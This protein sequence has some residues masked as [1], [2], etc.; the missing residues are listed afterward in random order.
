MREITSARSFRRKASDTHR[1]HTR[2]D[3][4]AWHAFTFY[5][6]RLAGTNSEEVFLLDYDEGHE[7]SSLTI[8]DYSV[9]SGDYARAPAHHKTCTVTPSHMK[10]SRR[11][12]KSSKPKAAAKALTSQIQQNNHP[13]MLTSCINKPQEYV[14]HL[15]YL[16]AILSNSCCHSSEDVLHVSRRAV[17]AQDHQ[18]QT[19]TRGAVVYFVIS[20]Q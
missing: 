15:L 4:D 7:K 17:F 1:L 5:P 6:T 16:E 18:S 11:L 13:L 19:S 20:N 8:V 9:V 10:K 2:P 12:Q 14:I 3:L